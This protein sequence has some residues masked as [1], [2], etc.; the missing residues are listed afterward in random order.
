MI[1]PNYVA[2]QGWLMVCFAELRLDGQLEPVVGASPILL[3]TAIHR[4][5]QNRSNRKQNA[6]PNT[7]PRRRRCRTER[8]YEPGWLVSAEHQIRRCR[9]AHSLGSATACSVAAFPS[10]SEDCEELTE[11]KAHGRNIPVRCVPLNALPR[12][13]F[14]NVRVDK[15]KVQ[16]TA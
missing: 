2:R 10:L 6:A 8:G 11:D 7:D 14:D 4:S 5:R 16:R 12:G 13:F 9:S 3:G 1:T 15:S